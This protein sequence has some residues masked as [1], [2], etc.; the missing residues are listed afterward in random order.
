MTSSA[1]T[2]D[3]PSIACDASRP[4]AFVPIAAL[5]VVLVA[6]SLW[7][8]RV[9]DVGAG[10]LAS[11]DTARPKTLLLGGQA[12]LTIRLTRWAIAAWVLALGVTDLVMGLVAQA[13]GTALRSAA[14][15]DEAI[16][17]L[18]A[19]GV[20]ATAY[21]GFVFVF[22]AG[23]VA[24][25]VA[26]QV[27]AIRNEEAVGHLENLLV[28]PVARWRWL[29]VRL[30]VGVGLVVI[31]GLVAGVAAWLGAISQGAHVGLGELLK[32][33]LNVVPPAV[34]ILGI[35]GFAF[36][37]WP[38]G[39]VGVAYGLVVWSFL[40]EVLAAVLDSNHWFRDTSPLLHMAPVPA[41]EPNVTAAV[42]LVALGVAAALVGIDAFRRRD[43]VGA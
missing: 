17:R 34:F 37:V 38:R 39:A 3:D 7:I 21:L 29:A 26:G 36:G 1:D 6:V 27:A 23:L 28:R 24:V 35:G 25:A 10:V 16:R 8:A 14:G 22:A 15:L 5:V 9:R 20:G 19:G 2:V 11:R 18:G 33:G 40:V 13:A 4:F 30:G 41:A 31:A 42:W 12:G 32:A 43:L